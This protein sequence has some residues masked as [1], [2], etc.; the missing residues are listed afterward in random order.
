MAATG[1]LVL[2]S[3]GNLAGV[4]EASNPVEAEAIDPERPE[5]EWWDDPG[6]PW[7]HKPSRSDIA[8]MAWIGFL[9]LF[10]L[11]M[12]PLRG[13]LLGRSVPLLVALT[14]SRS[15]TAGLG[16]LVAVGE[17]GA[18]WWPVLLGTLMSIKF[19][20]I[21][22]WAGKLWGRGMIEVWAGQS[23]RAARNYARV[24]RWAGK[25]GVL[26]MFIAY[27]PIPLPIMGVVF[28]LAGAQGMSWKKFV[29][30]DFISCL[31]WLLGYFLLGYSIGE[32]AVYVLRQYAKIANY[33]A[34]ALVVFVLGTYYYGAAKKAKADK[35][36]Q[37]EKAA[38]V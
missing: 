24:E 5:R 15:A 17:Y 31:V 37:A 28:V 34:I 8:C 29:A 1:N 16:S 23:E 18:W 38:Q 4:S 25:W 9:G 26:G 20:W 32:P 13:W 7:K 33:V 3:S 14:G 2:R 6:M 36:A 30:L 27:V 21:Y 10:S 11:A 19:D 35:A 22:W 12:L